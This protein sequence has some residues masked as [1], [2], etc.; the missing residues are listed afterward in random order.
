MRITIGIITLVIVGLMALNVGLISAQEPNI[1]SGTV[2][3]ATT[4]EPI[5]GAVVQVDGVDPVLSTQTDASGEYEIGDVPVGEQSVTAS[6]DGY[7]SE[8]VGAEVSETEGASVGFTLQPL[9]VEEQE[10]VEVEQEVDDEGGKVAGDRQ[11]YVGTYASGTGA[12]IVT[13]KQGEIEIQIPQEGLEPITRI[14][15]QAGGGLEDGAQI[16]VLV[17]FVDQGAA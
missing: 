2:S 14:P 9:D 3:D 4:G 16:A 8:T 15:D 12:F 11:G 10:P 1:I 7:E 5:E 13:T 6:A 17:E